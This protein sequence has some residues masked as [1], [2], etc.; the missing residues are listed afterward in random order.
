MGPVH[1]RVVDTPGMGDIRGQEVDEEHTRQIVDCIQGKET[2]NAIAL[3]VRGRQ[4]RMTPQLKLTLSQVCSV[5]PQSARTTSLSSF[6]TRRAP[7]T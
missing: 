1:V 7:C 4:A 5:L 2:V 6:T 3:V